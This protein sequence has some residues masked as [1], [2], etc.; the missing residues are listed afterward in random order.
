MKK[1]YRIW[2]VM[3]KEILHILRDKVVFMIAFIAP[4]FLST[5]FGFVYINEKVTEIPIVI[6]DEDKSDISRM[7]IRAFQDSERLK[8][9]KIAESYSEVESLMDRQEV[10]MAV[11]IPPHLKR[12][13]KTG[14]PSQVA[15]ILNGTNILIMN[16][17]SSAA[18]QITQTL[19]AGVTIKIM[20]GSGTVKQKAYNSLTAL[21]FKAR[22]W[23]N[24]TAS[25]LQFMLLGL[26]GTILQ[27][28][29]LLAIAL[30]FSKERETGT[31]KNLM[32]S[33]LTGFEIIIGKFLVYFLIFTM[34]G[35]I[36]Y[37][38]ASR[39]FGI[40]P[41]G[42]M[43]LIA[44]TIVLFVIAILVV[45]MALSSVIKSQVQAIEIS[46]ILAVPSFILSGYT[47]PAMSMPPAIQAVSNVFPLTHFLTAV[48][49]EYLMGQGF[50]VVYP[51]LYPLAL[52]IVIA[53][54][55]TAVS[56]NKRLL[57]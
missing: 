30:S 33:N 34:N 22:V 18:S 5:F 50:D 32:F 26:I 12:D 39:V 57:V 42:D 8:T 3:K 11:L 20:E 37:T 10:Q 14:V 56:V 31:W 47:W 43:R 52:F 41:V 49:L 54:P 1:I 4:L 48:K 46:M 29:A 19:A 53:L 9:V 21:S 25:Y 2:A 24:Q 38:V 13:L 44:G 45:G 36:L 23:Y 27:Q 55:I 40:T 17:A 28:L 7:I 51:H 16:T 6:F 15:V 35:F